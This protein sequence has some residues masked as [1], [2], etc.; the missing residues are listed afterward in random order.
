MDFQISIHRNGPED[1]SEA[2][3]CR[4][5]IR[6]GTRKEKALKKIAGL[7]EQIADA[8][9]RGAGLHVRVGGETPV[10]ELW[11]NDGL[12]VG[13]AAEG[14]DA[15]LG[16]RLVSLGH[17][18]ASELA[19]AT[20]SAEME[21]V[22]LAHALTGRVRRDAL[23]E[24]A[25]AEARY[26]LAAA[27]TADEMDVTTDQEA[28]PDGT[29]AL[30]F[31][32]QELLTET[33]AF[34]GAI[35]PAQ[36]TAPEHA[37]PSPGAPPEPGAALSAEEW[38][39]LERCDGTS[40]IA[41][42]ARGCGLP[43]PEAS[44]VITRLHHQGLVV[45]DLAPLSASALL[46]ELEAAGD[47]AALSEAFEIRIAE[48]RAVEEEFGALVEPAYAEPT[49][50]EPSLPEIDQAPAEI[51]GFQIDTLSLMREL[52]SLAREETKR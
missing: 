48:E 34:M 41:E 21:S 42:I 39:V 10:A 11:L 36:E 8:I 20:R 27:L 15:R 47:L 32:A 22:P 49:F 44:V 26:A 9:H 50:A 17:L 3:V 46:E 24:I 13:A 6:M 18:P 7:D 37:V 31:G 33:L 1:Q 40:T 35:G 45:L 14:S 5:Q 2:P 30:Q 43:H 16:A 51:G 12:V 25:R 29:S 4:Q 19:T 28:R 23:T 52:A 38:A